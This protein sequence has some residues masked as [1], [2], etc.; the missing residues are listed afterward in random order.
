MLCGLMRNRKLQVMFVGQLVDS[1]GRGSPV[2][3]SPI[4]VPVVRGG[5]ALPL[6][7]GC[8]W[9]PTMSGAG[10]SSV[11]AQIPAS[12]AVSARSVKLAGPRR[13]EAI[14]RPLAVMAELPL[15]ENRKQYVHK[16]RVNAG[17]DGAMGPH[18]ERE[19]A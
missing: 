11:P 18:P 2:M 12:A 13:A 16:T 1:F 17:G 10:Y 7:S 4:E 3:I 14:R 8:P 5:A 6:G 19:P 9:T 15:V